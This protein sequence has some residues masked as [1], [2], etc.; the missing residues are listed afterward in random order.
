MGVSLVGALLDVPLQ[1]SEYR[2]VFC[3]AR[4]SMWMQS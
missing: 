3:G 1:E 2:R 4:K